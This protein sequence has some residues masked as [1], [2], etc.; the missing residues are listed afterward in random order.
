M[1]PVAAP[2]KPI[3]VIE[4]ALLL[5]LATLW[6][7]SFTFLK[8]TVATIPPLTTIAVRTAIAGA[9]LLLLMRWQG[10]SLPRDKATLLSFAVV[11]TV[12]TVAPFMLIAW[13]IQHIDAGLAVIL[14][15]T[16]PIFAFLITWGLT[17]HEPAT[18]RKLLGVSMGIAGIVLIVGTEALFGLGHHILPQLAIVLAALSYAT[19]A[20]YGSSFRGMNP[21]APAAGSLLI[22]AAALIPLAI[23]I[24]RP[25]TAAPSTAS[26]T[27]LLF[28]AVVCTALGNVLYFRLLG[29]L[30]SLGTTAQSYLRVPIGVLAGIVLLGETLSPTAAM[31]LVGV[32]AGVAAMTI[33]PGVLRRRRA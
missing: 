21:M 20:V 16:T 28:L 22:G 32:V 6:G 24:E 5:V 14:N 2:K 3:P 26:L 1:Q 29:T 25:W 10:L 19:S 33:P 11:A 8:I 4:Y 27:S 7:A 18:G 23:M 9:L 12:N 31:G 15:S 17:R 30:G 13:G